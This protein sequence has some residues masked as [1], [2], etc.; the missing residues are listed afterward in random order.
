MV[1]LLGRSVLFFLTFYFRV[2]KNFDFFHLIRQ[3]TVLLTKRSKLII[4]FSIN[5]LRA[6]TYWSI[7]LFL[8]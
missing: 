6:N 1:T 7:N 4:F 5:I 8:N 2:R 3:L